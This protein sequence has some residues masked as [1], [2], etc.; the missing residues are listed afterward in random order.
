VVPAWNR[1]EDIRRCLA[2]LAAQTLPAEAFEII[3]VD[4][5]STDETPE[6]ARSVPGVTVLIESRPG[7]YAARNT[8]LAAARGRYVAFT[9]SDC[10]P[11]PRWLEAALTAAE[12]GPPGLVAGR[13]AFEA[14]GPQG[15]SASEAF[16]RAF[17]FD[18]EKNVRNGVAA[19]AN[20]LVERELVAGLG[21]FR[22]DLKSGGDFELARRIGAT[23]HPIRYAADAVVYHPARVTFA[24]LSAKARRVTGGVIAARGGRRAVPKRAFESTKNTAYRIRNIWRLAG[25]PARLKLGMSLVSLGLLGAS[26]GELGRIALGGEARRA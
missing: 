11:D 25:T 8:G 15:M 12:A 5:G 17:G 24:E 14:P 1:P 20:W 16:E 22:A 26:L 23:G 13:V 19:T 3:V 2:G 6:V 9:D 7:S 18:Q 4:N 21:G 10:T